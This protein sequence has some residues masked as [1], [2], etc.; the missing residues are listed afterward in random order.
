MEIIKN[1]YISWSL[2]ERT[3][4]RMGRLVFRP[5]SSAVATSR[6]GHRSPI[7]RPGR[8]AP[9][10]GARRVA[11]LGA[12]R[13]DLNRPFRDCHHSGLMMAERTLTMG[14]LMRWVLARG[15]GAREAL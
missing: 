14:R 3:Q 4:S 9:A 7:S 1:L 8:P 12:G 15:T 2:R 11:R 5:P 6:E 13:R 10:M